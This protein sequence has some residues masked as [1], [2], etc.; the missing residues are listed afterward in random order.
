MA[1][2]TN[3]ELIDR[4]GAKAALQLTTDLG[5]TVDQDVLTEVC[6]SAEGEANGYLAKR[7]QVPVDLTTH[8]DLE[9]TLRGFTLDIAVYRLRSRRQPVSEG[10]KAARDEAIQWLERVA[11]GKIVL[12]AAVTPTSTSA[13]DPQVGWGSNDPNLSTIGDELC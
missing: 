11:E 13:D 7:Y 9:A 2:I 3:Q 12:P 8:T 10:Y 4:V 5:S 6:Q 1:Y